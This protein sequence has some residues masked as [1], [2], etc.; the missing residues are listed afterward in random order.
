MYWMILYDNK[1][2]RLTVRYPRNKY[3]WKS[4]FNILENDGIKGKKRSSK[5]GD[6]LSNLF[7]KVGRLTGQ[8]INNKTEI[9]KKLNH[10]D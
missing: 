3:I 9:K 1:R 7:S 4:E 2:I 6:D 8:K 10:L 5:L